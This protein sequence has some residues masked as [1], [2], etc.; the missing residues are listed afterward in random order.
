MIPAVSFMDMLNLESEASVILTD[1]GGVQKEAWF[2]KKPVV[3]LRNE[4]EWV[5]IISSGNGTL[6]GAST[7]KI[8]QATRKYLETP[9]Q[10]FPPLFG[11]G[12]AAQ[13]ILKVLTT[14]EWS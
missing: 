6:T 3:V 13:E 5:E 11:N 4:T 10:H 1:S 12:Q 8:I 2:M 14:T 9:P 7:E